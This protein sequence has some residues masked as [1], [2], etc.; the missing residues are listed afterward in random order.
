MN[1]ISEIKIS[2]S[3]NKIN[4]PPIS[5]AKDAFDAI[6]PFF[7]S[8]SI[9]LQES[10]MVAYLNT[11]HE[12]LGVLKHT[13]GSINATLTDVRIILG[14]AL[15]S[16]ATKIIIAHNHPSS[17]LKESNADINATKKLKE[18]AKMFDIELL[19]HLIVNAKGEYFSF[20]ENELM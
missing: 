20:A 18:A 7:P 3:T 12:L 15:K 16:M 4:C 13:T 2:Y 19:D 1:Q 5:N 6:F 8:D 10:F 14:V 9:E 11:H 17:F